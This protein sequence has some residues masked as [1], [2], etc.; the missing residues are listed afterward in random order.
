MGGCRQQAAA[1]ILGI[2]DF[3]SLLPLHPRRVRWDGS[4][5][6]PVAAASDPKLDLDASSRGV[7]RDLRSPWAAAA[8]LPP[9][10][11]VELGPGP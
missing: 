10:R 5:A 6:I 11:A 3:F 7:R 1:G 2:L 4:T 9:V 8:A